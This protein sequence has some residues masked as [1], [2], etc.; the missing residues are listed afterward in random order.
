MTKPTVEMRKHQNLQ[1][2]VRNDK[3]IADEVYSEFY[4]IWHKM[5]KTTVEKRTY[6]ILQ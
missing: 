6:Q 1:W 2:V 5:T 4:K 3:K